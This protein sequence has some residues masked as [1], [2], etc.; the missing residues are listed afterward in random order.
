MQRKLVFDMA[1]E[2][3]GFKPG[4]KEYSIRNNKIFL[5]FWMVDYYSVRLD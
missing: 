1:K 3:L 4:G 5:D 2:E